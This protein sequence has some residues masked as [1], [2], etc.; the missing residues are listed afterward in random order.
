[1]VT[2]APGSI[3]SSAAANA[4]GVLEV[5]IYTC[6]GRGGKRCIEVSI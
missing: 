1:M 5:M 2:L 6:E 3:T 4:Q